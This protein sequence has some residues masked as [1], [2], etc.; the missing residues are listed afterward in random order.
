MAEEAKSRLGRGLAALI[1]EVNDNPPASS[2]RASRGQ[3]RV[4]IEF[5]R[6]NPKNPRRQFSDA[7][8][9]E[10]AK[11]IRERGVIQPVVV[12][13]VA[14]E[15][16]AYE[17]IAG[18]RRWR[19]SQRAGL[20]QLP[21]V[22][23]EATDREAL[24]LAIIENVQRQDLNPLE[25]ALGYKALGEEYGHGQEDIAR[26]VGKS[27]SHVANT[28]RLLN[29][30]D[31]VKAFV[32]EG[33]LSAG[34]ARALL[35]LPDPEAVAR[36]VVEKG[37]NVRAVETIAQDAAAAKGKPVRARVAVEK[38]PNTRALERRLSDFLGL[39]VSLEHRGESGEMRIR[40]KSLDQLDSLV[41]KLGAA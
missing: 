16:D 10:L 26:V 27:R 7:E 21:I 1:G 33:K 13:Q 8:L 11:S 28:L 30:P 23:I 38:D 34:H 2:E 15:Q 24:E 4:P 14:G 40:Y 37:L 35:A 20:H 5:I 12:R 19:A 9:E 18:E 29:L 25:E 6:A 32:S 39:S 41:M 22:L 31:S 3:R 17:I 36:E